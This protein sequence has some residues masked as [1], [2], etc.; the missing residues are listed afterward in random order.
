MPWPGVAEPLRETGGELLLAGS[1]TAAGD[2]YLLKPM[3]PC[4]A[5]EHAWD[6]PSAGQSGSSVDREQPPADAAPARSHVKPGPSL[7][8][9]HPP[10]D[11]PADPPVSV[12]Q[13]TAIE[14]TTV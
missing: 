5:G 13:C 7:S 10:L 3:E 9:C 12:S 8:G 6:T 2:G 14:V 4:R 1:R 11:P